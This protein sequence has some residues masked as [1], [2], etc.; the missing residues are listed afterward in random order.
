MTKWK[1]SIYYLNFEVWLPTAGYFTEEEFEQY[2]EDHS[3]SEES[4]NKLIFT[5]IEV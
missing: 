3:L 5:E 1:F 4:Y 2:A